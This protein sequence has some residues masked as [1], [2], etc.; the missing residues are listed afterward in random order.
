LSVIVSIILIAVSLLFDNRPVTTGLLIGS[1]VSITS[2]TSIWWT[3]GIVFKK[4]ENQNPLLT[5]LAVLVYVIKLPIIGIALYFA[6]QYLK[7]N[8]L[9]LIAGLTVMLMAVVLI[10]ISNLVFKRR[11]LK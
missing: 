11:A 6:F 4:K 3:I 5:V 10:G 7:I 2:F 8:L 1:A 9:A